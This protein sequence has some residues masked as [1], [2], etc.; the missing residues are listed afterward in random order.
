MIIY[1]VRHGQTVWN[2]KKILQGHLN[3]P[4]TIKGEKSARRNAKK[5]IGKNISAIYSSDLGRCMQ[6]AEIINE[7]LKIE[8]FPAKQL[9]ERN[10]GDY[11][12]RSSAFIKKNLTGNQIPA[13]GESIVDFRK[14][15]VNFIKNLSGEKMEKILLVLHEGSARA[16]ISEYSGFDISSAKCLTSDEKVYNFEINKGLIKDKSLKYE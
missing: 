10:F 7:S 5:L 16:I 8:I 14:R 11:N 9:R 1:F 2:K 13:N 3:S 15:V 12:G 6:T 4:L